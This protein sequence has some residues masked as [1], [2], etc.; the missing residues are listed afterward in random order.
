MT[1]IRVQAED[2][3]PGEELARLEALDI[4]AVASFTGLVRGDNGLIALTLEHYPAMTEN[5]L[6]AIADEAHRRWPLAGI[7]IIHRHG[8]LLPGE[9]IVFVATASSHRGAALEAC[10]FLIDWLKTDAPFWKREEQADGS[11]HWI[12]AREADLEAKSRWT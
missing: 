1:V 4:G 3:D 12:E 5:A 8:R 6:R 2:F 11:A 7:T 10:A 9:H